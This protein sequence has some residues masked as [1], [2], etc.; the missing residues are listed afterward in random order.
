[1][2]TTQNKLYLLTKNIRKNTQLLISIKKITIFEP[3][4]KSSC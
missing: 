2:L 4:L 1:M 3:K